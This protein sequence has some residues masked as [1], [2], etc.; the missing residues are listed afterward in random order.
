MLCSNLTFISVHNP[1][2]AHWMK[3]GIRSNKSSSPSAPDI[4]G[5]V[6]IVLLRS[7][8]LVCFEPLRFVQKLRRISM[9]PLCPPTITSQLYREHKI[10]WRQLGGRAV[11]LFKPDLQDQFV[12]HYSDI[13]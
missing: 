4:L 11:P 5:Q 6:C 10:S 7:L 2:G 8:V 9:C 13:K 1:L 3:K 12:H